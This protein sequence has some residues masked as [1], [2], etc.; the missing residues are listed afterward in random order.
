MPSAAHPTSR[1]PRSFDAETPLFIIY[2]SGTTGKPEGARAHV[3]AG[4]S[5]SAAW[6]PLGAF[7]AKPDDV[8]WCTADLAWVTAH[9][10]R[11]LRP[12]ANGLTQVIYEGTPDT[13]HPGRHFEIIER[14]GVTTY[15]TA[16]TLIRTFMTWFPDGVPAEYDLSTIRLLGIGRRGDQPRRVGVVPRRSS[17]PAA[18]RSSTPGGSP[19]PAPRSWRRCP[20]SRRSSP[21]RRLRALPGLTTRVVDEHGDDVAPRR[22]RLPRRSTA[23][24]RAWRAPCGA[25]P[26]A[27]AT[28]TGRGSRTAATFF[29]GDGAKVDADGDI[30]LLG[31]VDDVINVSGHRLSTIEIESAL[32]AHPDGRPRPASSAW[33]TSTTGEAIAAFVV[34]G[35]GVEGRADASADGRA[36]AHGR[37]APT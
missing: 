8:H 31:R 7:D 26:S 6:T 15:Y 34:T 35:D 32:V 4:T 18:P 9:I 11:A 27:T 22:G 20:E 21:A 13:P 29:S 12:A 17:A 19:R 30:W 5:R 25:T 10:V 37:C 24:G 3:A 14:Y 36:L 2:T 33:P 23:R 28:R 1:A 16:P